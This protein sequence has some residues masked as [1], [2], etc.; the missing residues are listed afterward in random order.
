MRSFPSCWNKTLAQL[1]F[2]RVKQKKASKQQKQWQRQS[3]IESLEPRQMLAA[4][5]YVVS[6]L[7][8]VVQVGTA[9]DDQWSLREALTHSANDNSG[10]DTINFAEALEGGRIELDDTLGQLV[11]DSEV[12]IEGPGSKLLTIDAQGQSRVFAID[13]GSVATL[14]DITITGGKVTGTEDGAGIHNSGDLTLERVAVINNETDDL[15]GG[16]FSDNGTLS[17]IETTVDGNQASSGGGL[18]V[19]SQP[20]ESVTIDRSTISNNLSTNDG[21]GLFISGD[22]NTTDGTV[23]ITNSTFSGNVSGGAGG[24][25]ATLNQSDL[26]ITSSTIT[27]NDANSGGGIEVQGNSASINNTIISEN[28]ATSAANTAGTITGSNNLIDAADAG[29][30]ALGDHGGATLTH[31]LLPNSPAID[32]GNDSLATSL[33]QRG[34][35]R[36]TNLEG[37]GSSTY[38][39]IG[40]VE[41]SPLFVTTS[42]EA[43]FNGDGRSDELR[44]DPISKNL[45]VLAADANRDK[46]SYQVWGQVTI[47]SANGYDWDRFKVGDFNG[48]GRDDFIAY[49]DSAAV[50]SSWAIGISDG[51]TFHVHD[52]G[53]T[54]ITQEWLKDSLTVGDFDGDGSDE[55]VVLKSV[56]DNINYNWEMLQYSANSGVTL[57]TADNGLY[58]GS[59]AS[60][61][62][63]EF[64][65]DVHQ[66]PI[67]AG[68]VDEDGRDDLLVLSQG[69]TWYAAFAGIGNDGRETFATQSLSDWYD[70]FSTGSIAEV[71]EAQQ[72]IIAEFEKVYN[73][74]ELEIYPGL[75]KG[76]EATAQTKAGNPWDQAALLTDRLE[77]ILDPS[78]VR[79]ASGEI[80]APISVL[81]DWLGVDSGSAALAVIDRG[82]D[83]FATLSGGSDIRFEHAWVQVRIPTA[84]GLQWVD[85]DPSWKF[86]DRQS[87]IA[88]PSPGTNG[89]FDEFAFFAVDPEEDQ[90][91]P[92]E[93]FEDQLSELLVGGL[94]V[95]DIPFDGPIIRNSFATIPKG[96]GEGVSTYGVVSTYENFDFIADSSSLKK[97]LTHR[98]L[99]GV[100]RTAASTQTGSQQIDFEDDSDVTYKTFPS[101][102]LEE[103]VGSGDIYQYDE[104]GGIGAVD[105]YAS[106]YGLSAAL[107]KSAA[108]YQITPNTV[109]EFKFQ[110][111]GK[112]DLHYIGWDLDNNVSNNDYSTNSQLF[113]VY[114]NDLTGQELPYELYSGSG[115]E[116]I[117]I[118]IGYYLNSTSPIT[119]SRLFFGHQAQSAFA[120]SY[121][122]SMRLYEDVGA[123]G[124][125]WFPS[126][127]ELIVPERGLDPISLRFTDDVNDALFLNNV[128]T[129][130]A[131]KYWSGLVVDGSVV[132]FSASDEFFR[133]HDT[134]KL[135]LAHY[136][137]T[138]FVSAAD[139]GA[140]GVTK[141]DREFTYTQKP[142]EIVSIGLEA[143]QHSRESLASLQE[144]LISE[145]ANNANKEDYL[146][147]FDLLGS[148][149]VAKY[150]HDFNRDTSLSAGLFQ[151]INIQ[152]WVGS[153]VVTANPEFLYHTPEGSSQ[154]TH[155]IDFLP[156]GFAPENFGIDLPNLNAAPLSRSNGAISNEL[157]QLIS[158]NGSALEHQIVEEVISSASISTVKGLQRAFAGVKELGPAPANNEFD[159]W[160]QVFESVPSGSTRTIY[161]R[162]NIGDEYTG[163]ITYDPNRTNKPVT[164]ANLL[165]TTVGDP[166]AYLRL[167]N[168]SAQQQIANILSNTNT[169]GSAREDAGVIRVIVTRAR[170]KLDNWTGSVFFAEIDR[171]SGKSAQMAIVPDGGPTTNG[172]FAGGIAY[173]QPEETPFGNFKFAAYA[174]DP[175]NT[176]NGNMYRDETDIILPNKGVPLSFSRHYDSQS[177][178]NIGIGVGWTHSFGDLLYE[179]EGDLVWLTSEGQQHRFAEVTTHVYEVP[180]A[181]HGTFD[182]EAASGGGYNYV[183][184][185]RSGIEYHFDEI[186]ATEGGLS[187]KGRLVNQ[188]DSSG[189]GIAVSYHSGY[190]RRISAVRD[191]TDVNRY[192]S[193]TYHSADGALQSIT[194]RDGV[195]PIATWNYERQTSNGVV[196]LTEVRA[197][198]ITS[199]DT[200]GTETSSQPTVTYDYHTSGLG[201]GLISQITEADGVKHAYD[202]YANGRTWRVRQ[203]DAGQSISD[204]DTQIFTY[205]QLRNLTEFT[206][207]R[208]NTET[209]IH[210]D[211]GL[212]SKQ[213]HADR[214][215]LTYQWGKPDTPAEFLMA[216]AIDEVGAIED[217]TYYAPSGNDYFDHLDTPS[218]YTVS[219]TEDYRWRELAKATSKHFNNPTTAQQLVDDAGLAIGDVVTTEFDYQAPPTGMPHL[220]LRSESVVNPGVGERATTYQYDD[221]GRL[222]VTTDPL[223]NETSRSYYTS[224]SSKGLLQKIVLPEGAGS[225]GSG[226]SGTAWEVLDNSFT[227]DSSG[228]LSVRLTPET[229]GTT[230]VYTDAIRITP[231]NPSGTAIILDDDADNLD[232]AFDTNSTTYA[233]NNPDAYGNDAW[234]LR[235]DTQEGI[236]TFENLTPGEY[237]IEATWFEDDEHDVGRYEWTNGT[238]WTNASFKLIDQSYSPVDTSEWTTVFRY[239]AAGNVIE[240]FT[241]G[242]TNGTSDYHI[243]G[244]P[245]KSEDAE[246]VTTKSEY[247]TLGWLTNTGF[248]DSTTSTSPL[249]EFES[250]FQYDAEGR[251]RITT[252]PLG[253]KVKLQYDRLGNVT[254]QTNPD[255]TVV[256]YE[257]D[258]FG[259]RIKAVDEL[260]RETRFFYDARNRLIQTI[261]ADGA[262]ERLRYDALGRVT[263]T[264]DAVGNVSS[265]TYDAAG[266]PLTS[267][268]GKVADLTGEITDVG[269]TISASNSYNAF[270][271][272]SEALDANG[273]STLFEYDLLGRVVETRS[274]VA[275]KN[276]SNHV[277]SDASE[278]LALTTTEFDANGNVERTAIYDVAAI[279]SSI[280]DPVSL[281]TSDPSNVQT[282]SITYDEYNRPIVVTNPDGTTT[283][284]EYDAAGRV[285]SQTDELGRVTELDYDQQGRL[286][287]TTLPDPDGTSGSLESPETTITY[288]GAGNQ[289]AL[290]D[291]VGN[292]T[293]FEHDVFNRPVV[294]IDAH[295]NRTSS[296]YD[297]AGQ[298]IAVVDALGRAGH[299]LYDN[300]GRVITQ[301]SP[302]PDGAGPQSPVTTRSKYDAAGRLVESIDAAGYSTEYEYNS[303]NR[304]TKEKYAANSIVIDNGDPDYPDGAARYQDLRKDSTT[305]L[306]GDYFGGDAEFLTSSTAGTNTNLHNAIAEYRFQDL[307]PGDYRVYATWNANASATDSADAFFQSH[308]KTYY[309]N[310]QRIASNDVFRVDEGQGHYWEELTDVVLV[311]PTTSDLRLWLRSDTDEHLVADAVR[312]ERLAE[313]TFTYDGNGN[314]IQQTDADGNTSFVTYDALNRTV[315]SITADPDGSGGNLP[316]LA[317]VTQYDGYSNVIATVEHTATIT[318]S[319]ATLTPYRTTEFTYDERNRLLTE[320]FAVGTSQ[321][322]TN[323]YTYDD[324]GNLTLLEEAVGEAESRFTASKYDDLNRVIETAVNADTTD[325][326]GFANPAAQVTTTRNHYDAA[327]NLLRVETDWH[328]NSDLRNL[329]TEYQYDSLHRLVSQS[330]SGEEDANLTDNDTYVRTYQYVYD[331][332]GNQTAV[333]DPLLNAGT[334]QYDRL[335]RVV[336]SVAPDPD[337]SGSLNASVSNFVYDAAGR[338]DSQS[339]GEAETRTFRYDA[340]GQVSQSTDGLGYTTYNRYDLRGNLIAEIDPAGNERSYSYDAL[341][342]MLSETDDSGNTSSYEFDSRGRLDRMTDRNGRVMEYDYDELDRTIAEYWYADTVDAD[343]GSYSDRL[344]WTYDL[345]GRIADN[346]F[347][348]YGVPGSA[349]DYHLRQR[350]Y[351]DGLDRVTEWENVNATGGSSSAPKMKQTY[352]FTPNANY[353]IVKRTEYLQNVIQGKETQLYSPFGEL[354]SLTISDPNP[355]VGVNY[356]RTNH[357]ISYD[358]AGR[359]SKTDRQLERV[360]NSGVFDTIARSQYT[361][362]D[363]DRLETIS[364]SRRPNQATFTN[365]INFSYA[366][367]QAHRVVQFTEDWN[368]GAAGLNYLGPNIP[369]SIERQ[370]DY[371]YDDAGQ[372]I[373][374]EN[375]LT[376]QSEDTYTYD[377]NGNRVT[378]TVDGSSTA[379]DFTTGD[380]NRLISDEQYSYT[381]DNEGNLTRRDSLADSSYTTYVWNHRNQLTAFDQYNSSGTAIASVDYWYNATGEL[382]YRRSGGANKEY[383]AYSGG[384]RAFTVERDNGTGSYDIAARYAYG[385]TGEPLM[386]QL[387]HTIGANQGEMSDLLFPLGDHQ[388]S[389]R[390]VLDADDALAVRQ[391]VEYTPFGEVDSVHDSLGV[392]DPTKALD[393]AFAHHGSVQDE[394]TGLSHKAARWYDPTIGRFLTEDPIGE[395]TNHYRFA[396]NDPV[397]FADPSGLSQEG[398]PTAGGY[399]G[400]VPS[401][402]AIGTG[403]IFA[404]AGLGAA[405]FGVGGFASFL[406]TSALSSSYSNNRTESSVGSASPF[407]GPLLS[408][409]AS[410]LSNPL[411][412]GSSITTG[413]KN[414]GFKNSRTLGAIKNSVELV[415][416]FDASNQLFIN[417]PRLVLDSFTRAIDPTISVERGTRGDLFDA[418]RYLQARVDNDRTITELLRPAY[419][420]LRANINTPN[421]ADI[422]EQIVNVWHTAAI[423][424]IALRNATPDVRAFKGR[425]LSFSSTMDLDGYSRLAGK[426]LWTEPREP[427]TLTMENPAIKPVWGPEIAIGGIGA[428]LFK[429]GVGAGL[430]ATAE[431]SISSVTGL[432]TILPSGSTVKSFGSRWFGRTNQLTTLDPSGIRF[433]QAT[434]RKQGATVND[435]TESMRKNGFIAEPEPG[436]FFDVVRMSD[437][438]L[439]TLDNTRLLAARRA[440]VNVQARVFDF[441]TSLPSNPDFV[442]RFLGRKGEVPTTFGEAV[443]N[444]IGK[445]NSG[446][447]TA[448]PLGSPITGSAF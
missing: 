427:F 219:S 378:H 359:L 373:D 332:V 39:D 243:T 244:A 146:H 48:D 448:H 348:Y 311:N 233:S 430:I 265:Q 299:T 96:H 171:A 361:Y 86:K 10:T 73:E 142:G 439:T 310:N 412:F 445:Q 384:R 351:Y 208:G 66:N 238:N 106:I 46:Q 47:D 217:F 352:D 431:E 444:R 223:G 328:L 40:A 199:V 110:A 356:L 184:R 284:T 75:M 423:A 209:Y 404:G 207:E 264:I 147:D 162:G 315:A 428:A 344:L 334:S 288:D 51:T 382:V 90:Q 42:L 326:A 135:N 163:G 93:F 325:P 44:Y 305:P 283:S 225:S 250:K 211:N 300:R 49:R 127:Y 58:W 440:G 182:R 148:Y 20:G 183:F 21:A 128:A 143:N 104:S 296:V 181:L 247:N 270:G 38:I 235:N 28:E 255:G 388:H 245:L 114:G 241:E 80:V 308:N 30:T 226:G 392:N 293:R 156:Y 153:G 194:R 357:S 367:D 408:S 425:Q 290:T 71:A 279:Q 276:R 246:G 214:S 107:S 103:Y 335:N 421:A 12:I 55:L 286:I 377:A 216:R 349:P 112:Q 321:E 130:N 229:T 125:H 190:A 149:T 374:V 15:G 1:G 102:A 92:I 99:I 433:S 345:R 177:D 32:Q 298:M 97:Q 343:A 269:S 443:L 317:S 117:S 254:S 202:Y 291:P 420:T 285:V 193:F 224:G 155:E 8:D 91:T 366:Y 144:S 390:L 84:S 25:I 77:Q 100:D 426:R 304:L 170:Q 287:R 340:M 94:S 236:W 350:Y 69:G 371:I 341:N 59:V 222:T 422:S 397:N 65:A 118:P 111:S 267:T 18:W 333:L 17:I 169:D 446:F 360:L 33:D 400:G 140:F 447:R 60:N 252:D 302:D 196:Q 249:P 266:R 220:R 313:R 346:T 232:L 197:P 179:D 256:Q 136:A 175:V 79:I 27:S 43:D 399:S 150:W 403:A 394:T 45:I 415:S 342:R 275:G 67:H 139:T 436:K 4:D 405:G 72:A 301:Y 215:Q 129:A 306:S 133:R 124:E 358:T 354:R 6:T 387:F 176:A 88:L 362:D 272:L 228:I 123:T 151:N 314:L 370:R 189:N 85:L 329:E 437:G 121:F 167:Q 34:F 178:K 24:G 145:L 81:Q 396:G 120:T 62:F 231:L 137:P 19:A 52:V 330:Q 268:S 336:S 108:N 312:V 221:F 281:I 109:L 303:L 29:L 369:G 141:Y 337:G 398:K 242:Q 119:I 297:A 347:T 218:N 389:T 187:L 116:T 257:Y 381:Y 61:G 138:R 56:G 87:G 204:G 16:V 210:Q 115:V 364:H 327:G 262:T 23:T 212:L 166:N 435:L 353:D 161:L 53:Q 385:A 64:A 3:R 203:A 442:R 406:G 413:V 13:A 201:E 417:E 98:V 132:R 277:R 200:L 50:D 419:Q 386:D 407:T 391:T 230:K 152:Q 157:F 185:D 164:K 168:A 411:G 379:Q 26:T 409:L 261:H 253:N 198:A 274:L 259:N 363:A 438:R 292:V 324:V 376:T 434:V 316:H 239:D 295:G 234:R 78:D 68:D 41:L 35:R 76:P 395:G 375:G 14:R 36:Q 372:L 174:G 195:S 331:A 186:S 173:N 54:L 131:A 441:N 294:T 338:L 126:D 282:T 113:G 122:G 83:N 307:E 278:V 11:I 240:T 418:F 322:V 134:V 401:N 22:G 251:I 2:R 273:N 9:T 74:V 7:E 154:P 82:L 237:Q 432:P 57:S 410:G 95:S 414:F 172:G 289:I 180:S 320:T 63:S 339:N 159:G 213:I 5:T 323:A 192:L 319:T 165:S 318:G 429:G 424:D 191:I 309:G 393:T 271:Q 188:I 37:D 248:G 383:Y 258:G 206:D 101:N 31:A 160:L 380:D 280:A 89:D 260:G 365:L 158:L 416:T 205:N 355:N 105:G 263:E 402:G 70:N 227:V 368:T